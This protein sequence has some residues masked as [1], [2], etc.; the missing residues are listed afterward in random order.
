MTT[1][2][3]HRAHGLLFCSE[4]SMPEF[5]EASLGSAD[6]VIRLGPE[7]AE[8]RTEADL[9]KGVFAGFLS[10]PAGPVLAVPEIADFLVRDGREILIT[11]AEGH[12]PGMLRLYLQGSVIGMLFHQ[13]GQLVLH[14]AAVVREGKISVFTGPSGAGKSTLAAHLGRQGFAV[15]ADDTLPLSRTSYGG[16]QAWPGSRVFKLWKDALERIG[17]PDG[18]LPPIGNRFDK[19]MFTNPCAAPDRPAPL[20]EIILLDRGDGPA[21]LAEVK[22]LEAMALVA[23]NAYRPEYVPLLGRDAAHFRLAAELSGA[24]RVLRLTRPWDAA[25]MPE[26]LD[27]LTA[28]W[29]GA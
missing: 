3:W 29:S 10:T 16:F 19:F 26:T 24:V 28:H 14:G 21:Q 27:C 7:A 25:R 13:R 2:F 23:E 5:A 9:A 1:Q 22:G 18:D 11:P 17:T 20:A 12:E 4:I 8:A 6:V 15:L